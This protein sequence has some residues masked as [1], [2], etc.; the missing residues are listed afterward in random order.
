M[1]TI[2]D[3]LILAG[4]AGL[5]SGEPPP[6]ANAEGYIRALIPEQR[7]VFIVKYAAAAWTYSGFIKF[8]QPPAIYLRC[9]TTGCDPHPLRI[10][11]DLRSRVPGAYGARGA[12]PD[13]AQIEIYVATDPVE[14]DKRDLEV[15]KALHI[16]AHIGSKFLLPP[17]PAPCRTTIYFD[18]KRSTIEKTMI[19]IDSDASPRMQSLCMG[20][21][22]VRAIGAIN[23]A[24][25][26]FYH[27]FEK[28]SG[29]DPLPYLAANVFLH[30]S[31]E[32]HAGDPVEKAL[33]IFKDRYGLQ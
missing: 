4:V 32:I 23:V 24:G 14:F 31:T 15:D 27:E 5:L 1:A 21:E 30:T 17:R 13:T 33:A 12:E 16:D 22:L 29:Y 8:R 26:L 7:L 2:A 19:F 20:F 9:P 25:P 28:H 3:W 6:E 10:L 18:Q 11:D